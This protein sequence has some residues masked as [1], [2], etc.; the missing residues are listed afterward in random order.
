MP[1]GQLK[2]GSHF[3]EVC[4][5]GFLCQCK[6]CEEKKQE[7]KAKHRAAGVC[8]DCGGIPSHM[9]LFGSCKTCGPANVIAK[10]AKVSPK[11][12]NSLELAKASD[13]IA[14]T[15]HASTALF[16]Q[17]T[18]G[19]FGGGNTGGSLFGVNTGGGLF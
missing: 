15:G 5:G 6:R 13:A 1:D 3:E 17:N 14:T 11:N 19:L 7:R 12:F 16:G 2:Q 10:V 8:E 4:T 18:G 9:L